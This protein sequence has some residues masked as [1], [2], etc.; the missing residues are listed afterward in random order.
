MTHDRSR[1][2]GKGNPAF[3]STGS[4]A[5]G[6]SVAADPQP[7]HGCVADRRGGH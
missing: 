1:P 7:L 2:I 3:T 4:A 6:E 5:T